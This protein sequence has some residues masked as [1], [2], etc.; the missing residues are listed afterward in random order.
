MK[1]LE[2]PKLRGLDCRSVTE[3]GQQFLQLFNR[4]QLSEQMLQLPSALGLVLQY[5][6][7]GRTIEQIAVVVRD[8]HEVPVNPAFVKELAQ[9]LDQV[10]LLDGP[11]YAAALKQALDDYRKPGVRPMSC[12]GGCYSSDPIKLREEM[13]RIFEQPNGAGL[14]TEPGRSDDLRAVF[15]PHIDYRRGGPSFG[16]GFKELAERSRADVFVIVATSHYSP[17]RFS[18]TRNHFATPLGIVETDR[19]YVDALADQYGVDAAYEDELAHRPEH[20]IELEV[21]ILQ[22]LLGDRRPFKIVP[23]LVGP[24]QDAVDEDRSPSALPDVKRMIDALQSVEKS[25]GK[26]VC[27][28]I[29]GDLAHIG[30]KFGDEWT[31]TP[32]IAAD[33]RSTDEKLLTEFSSAD[34]N[35]F[36]AFINDE[37]DERRICGFPPGFTTLAATKPSAGRTLYQD[38]FV[39]P[40]GHEIVSFASVAFDR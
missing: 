31:I 25:Q 29:S 8:E 1:H 7:G 27:Y 39:D 36:S 12:V 19:D 18:L 6:D 37:N 23:L 16:Y 3:G 15:V 30:P 9:E 26:N 32:K 2:R 24:F 35:R 21:V 13:R 38:Q 5:F 28:L 14:P 20:S 34:P 17:A 40:K 4:E 11:T 33:N 10:L 22:Y